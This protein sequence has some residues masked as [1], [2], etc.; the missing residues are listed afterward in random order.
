MGDIL[1]MVTK[2]YVVDNEEQ[3][4]GSDGYVF[5]FPSCE[6]ISLSIHISESVT[7]VTQRVTLQVPNFLIT[8][9]KITVVKALKVRFE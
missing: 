9:F 8:L 4:V 6:T 3:T 1:N 5:T 7:L 2:P